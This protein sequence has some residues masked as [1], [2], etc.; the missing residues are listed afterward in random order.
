MA[1][2][3][4][5]TFSNGVRDVKT[6]NFYPFLV[7]SFAPDTDILPQRPNIRYYIADVT[8]SLASLVTDAGTSAYVS[9]IKWNESRILARIS[10]TT[11]L[12]NQINQSF[13]VGILLDKEAVLAFTAADITTA[14]V[15]VRYCEVDDCE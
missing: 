10:K 1:N 12:V 9:G 8:I 2:P 13:P 4:L 5:K 14:S 6:G 7:Q 3:I 15:T 11:L